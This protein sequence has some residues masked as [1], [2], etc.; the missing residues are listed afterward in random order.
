MERPAGRRFRDA[1][2]T[3]VPTREGWGLL[4]VAANLL[5]FACVTKRASLYAGASLALALYAVGHLGAAYAG[6]FLEASWDCPARV[7]AG[8]VF[9]LRLTVRNLGRALVTGIEVFEAHTGAARVAT[10]LPLL[11]ARA[12]AHVEVR[13]RVRRRGFHRL[14]GPRLRVSWP[15]RLAVAALDGGEDREVLA[16]P[17]RVPV[18]PRA[19]RSAAPEMS[20]RDR[21]AAVPRGGE[22]FRGVRDWAPGDPPRAIAWKA[23][24]HHDRLLT[25]E[26]EREDS[27]RAIVLLDADARD[28]A[29]VNRST[30]VETACSVAASLVLRL[31]GE[32][33]RVAFAAWT[34]EA[35]FV[36]SVSADRALGRALEAMALLQT[37]ARADPRRDPLSLLPAGSLRGARIVL[38]KAAIGPVRTARGPR[39]A[40]VVTVPSM[41]AAFAPRRDR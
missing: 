33:R 21:T 16:Y 13:G 11:E 20:S 5:L 12:A 6:T 34:P 35:L 23:S 22:V 41:Q 1:I 14:A 17:R 32:G 18:P 19:L 10:D 2:R 26:F 38:V 7:Y 37:P 9:P 3:T 4:L 29:A 25:R 39:G 8:E 15:F 24:A 40:E 28:L 30:A 36:P 31:R 27:G